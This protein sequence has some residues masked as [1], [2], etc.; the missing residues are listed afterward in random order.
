[1]AIY[2]QVVEKINQDYLY[3][4]FNHTLW[5]IAVSE[6]VNGICSRT[7]PEGDP[8]VCDSNGAVWFHSAWI[9]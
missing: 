8:I 2:Q 7:T 5:N 1:M 4:F 3:I 9:G 6:D